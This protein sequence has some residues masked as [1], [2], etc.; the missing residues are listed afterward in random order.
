ME[1]F[2]GVTVLFL[3]FGLYFIPTL[4]LSLIVCLMLRFTKFSSFVTNLIAVSSGVLLHSLFIKSV[5]RRIDLFNII[6]SIIT[7]LTVFGLMQIY[8]SRKNKVDVMI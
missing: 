7:Y 8:F 4:V 6:L 2:V 1:E 5:F 3:F